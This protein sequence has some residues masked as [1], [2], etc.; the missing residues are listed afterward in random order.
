MI[1]YETLTGRLPFAARSPVA[2]L[3]EIQRGAPVRPRV[4]RP[5]IPPALDELVM[6][7]LARDRAERPHDA[8]SELPRP[9]RDPPARA[10]A[11]A[12]AHRRAPRTCAGRSH[13]RAR[14]AVQVFARKV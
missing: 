9:P 1:L 12:G 6:Q 10:A 11:R 3:V 8:R 5:E 7:R 4:A 14:A 2:L 13:R